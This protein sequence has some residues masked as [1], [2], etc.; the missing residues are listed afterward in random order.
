MEFVD[1]S[2]HCQT[3]LGQNSFEKIKSGEWKIGVFADNADIEDEQSDKFY[4]N[5][6]YN[7]ETLRG[8]KNKVPVTLYDKS[9]VNAH[10]IHWHKGGKWFCV[11]F[12]P[13]WDQFDDS[14]Q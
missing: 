2:F 13:F 8:F 3:N 14:K 10:I 6:E 5:Y 1:A 12:H 7:G 4:T 9:Q 11:T